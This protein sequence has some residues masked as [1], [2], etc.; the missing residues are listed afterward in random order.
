MSCLGLFRTHSFISN[1]NLLVS[2]FSK[3]IKAPSLVDE[4]DLLFV[5][6]HKVI[7]GAVGDKIGNF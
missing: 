2:N 3:D 4:G 5:G 6:Y 1:L 7:V